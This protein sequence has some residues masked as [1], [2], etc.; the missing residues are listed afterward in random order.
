ML[1]V[2]SVEIYVVPPLEAGGTTASIPT[3]A[4]KTF[5][6]VRG[7]NPLL[8]TEFTIS[9]T[10]GFELTG[11]PGGNLVNGERFMILIAGGR[12]HTARI[13]E[14][15]DAV[16]ID[17]LNDY[18]LIYQ[19][20]AVDQT[21]KSV[22]SAFRTLI[23]TGGPATIQPALSA[24]TYIYVVPA[25]DAGTDTASIPQ[26]AGKS[27]QLRRAGL[28][29]MI[30]EFLPDGVTPNPDAEYQILAGGGFKLLKAGDLLQLN[31]RFE[32]VLY[33][34]AP[35]VGP[36]GTSGLEFIKGSKVVNANIS[37][38]DVDMNKVIHILDN[39][40]TP[41]VPNTLTLPDIDVVPE[42]SVIPIN[43]DI[44]ADGT[45]IEHKIQ[46]TGGQF[47]YMQGIARTFI[48]IRPGETVWL[49][50]DED[51]WYV[52]NDF[53]KIYDGIGKMDWVWK[54][55]RNQLTLDG[56]LVLTADY[57]RL[58]EYAQTLGSS[59]VTDVVWN[60]ASVAIG[61]GLTA[62]NVANPYRGCFSSGDGTHFR[63]PDFRN[64]SVRGLK[65]FVGG[66]DPER[67]INKAGVFQ[68]DAIKAP[69][70]G[71]LLIKERVIAG[72]D[73]DGFR[74]AHNAPGSDNYD[75][76]LWPYFTSTETRGPNIGLIPVINC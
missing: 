6:L 63:L 37:L 56:S 2:G 24:G 45:A 54:K 62:R 10:G 4:G 16:D 74:A 49:Y 65:D 20:G 39:P 51:G 61:A 67:A 14:L 27:F 76:V 42:N 9:P 22:L 1:A 57:P 12:M 72:G 70:A 8:N 28:G 25:I 41:L 15:A 60:T 11:A 36:G 32:L 31:E 44:D 47:I 35:L 58:Y 71:T 21:R 46:T 75:P 17:L 59:Y 73:I 3:L 64:I 18:A 66:A 34:L 13:P 7:A 53:G 33:Q 55:G 69:P 19:G 43:T 29:M 40:T 48:Y 23:L 26:V 68:D 38:A 30:P 5:S 50:R 52:I